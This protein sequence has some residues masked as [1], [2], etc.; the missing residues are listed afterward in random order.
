MKYLILHTVSFVALCALTITSSAYSQAD[1]GAEIQ[2]AAL[3]FPITS[4]GAARID[5]KLYAYGGHMGGAHAYF[6]EDQSNKLLAFDL[7]SVEKGWQEI[8][9]GERLQGLGMVA[10]QDELIILGGFT[11]RNKQ[12]EKQDLHSSSQVRA[13]HTKKNTW[14]DLPSLPEPRSSHDAAIIGTSIYVA[15]GWNLQGD[16]NTNWHTTAWT[17]DLSQADPKWVR[18]PDPLF[19]RRALA[20]IAHENQLFV[21]GGMDKDGGPTKA[22]TIYDPKTQTWSEAPDIIGE[23][24][25]AGFGAA[26]WS[27]DHRLIVSNYEGDLITWDAEKKTW[28]AL[29]KTRDARFFHR[30]L[31][32]AN[33]KL[34]AI[35]GAS[36]DS[37]KFKDTEVIELK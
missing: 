4:F 10:F 26:G 23:K 28:K 31:P 1:K 2:V 36:M 16:G 37:G 13:Y 32:L 6:N 25:M 34:I 33:G 30:L 24:N 15:G 5:D 3:P 18:M 11:A 19:V 20:L 12:G 14:R 21:V 27:I 9:I 8:S 7:S 17:I 22:V 29:G 35:G